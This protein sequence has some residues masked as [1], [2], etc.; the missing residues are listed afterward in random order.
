MAGVQRSAADAVHMHA[1][2]FNT[3]LTDNTLGGFEC[4]DEHI[5]A[6]LR[7]LRPFDFTAIF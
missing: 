2:L 6:L 1:C 4:K 5:C 7:A 3:L